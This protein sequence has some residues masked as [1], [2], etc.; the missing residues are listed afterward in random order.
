MNGSSVTMQDVTEFKTIV[1]YVVYEEEDSESIGTDTIY[2]KV[3][4]AA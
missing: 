1:V 2:R 4:I 3:D